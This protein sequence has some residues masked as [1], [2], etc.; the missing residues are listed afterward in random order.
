MAFE[1]MW[2]ELTRQLKQQETTVQNTAGENVTGVA[3]QFPISLLADAPLAVDGMT[4]YACRFIS[5]GRKSGE[6][7]GT[8]TG[9]PAFYDPTTDT[10]LNFSDQSAV[11]I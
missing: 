4:T 8:G 9:V 1:S 7:A 10:W 5:D 2:R 6:G 3:F 11:L